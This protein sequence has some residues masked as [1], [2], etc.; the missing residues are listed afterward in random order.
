MAAAIIALVTSLVALVAAAA[1]P[2]DA[3]AGRASAI[4]GRQVNGLPLEVS[5]VSAQLQQALGGALDDSCE[6][7]T[8]NLMQTNAHFVKLRRGSKADGHKSRGKVQP[9]PAS[10]PSASSAQ[11]DSPPAL[12]LFQV[13]VQLDMANESQGENITDPGI[14]QNSGIETQV[15]RAASAAHAKVVTFAAVETPSSSMNSFA[16]IPGGALRSYPLRR[17]HIVM[18]VFM[19]LVV[20]LSVTTAVLVKVLYSGIKVRDCTP[21]PDSWGQTDAQID[22]ESQAEAGLPAV[23]TNESAAH[24][25]VAALPP[26]SVEDVERHLPEA[27]GYDCAISRPRSSG[28]PMRL[29]A[30][31][32]GPHAGGAC[33]AAPLTGRPCVLYS[34]GVSRQT[35]EGMH[36]VSLAFASAWTD[37]EVSLADAPNER[38]ELKGADI[39]L[40]DMREGRFSDFR[41]LGASPEHWQNFA[42][43]RGAMAKEEA[44]DDNWTLE[45]QECALLVGANVTLVGELHRRANGR[46]MLQPWHGFESDARLSGTRDPCSR[47][48]WEKAGVPEKGYLDNAK[49]HE[50]GTQCDGT[51]LP[52]THVGKVL[53]TDDP[54]LSSVD[55]QRRQAVG[56]VDL[57][58]Y[59]K[60]VAALTGGKP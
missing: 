16:W 21:F 3:S 49:R 32:E 26:C 11:D 18:M 27:H 50:V 10:K 29:A 24:A 39:S 55:V 25:H 33:L 47:T 1:A 58:I 37:F 4:G 41:H 9:L 12:S 31:V 52:P 36:P 57:S 46:L 38:I 45:F 8:L 60:P 28:R 23:K 54:R 48:S 5:P 53:V 51:D 35:H 43:T 13:D 6:S 30:R 40:F 20:L 42:L 44:P 2:A 22:A 34:A 7:G 56:R 14:V 59:Q 19:A 17:S 15:P